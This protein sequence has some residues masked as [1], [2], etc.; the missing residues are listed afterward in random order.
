MYSVIGLK[1][2]YNMKVYLETVVVSNTNTTAV[3][4]IIL[5]FE[6]EIA[7]ADFKDTFDG[8]EKGPTFEV[9]RTLLPL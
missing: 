5:E 1:L 3:S 7:F 8:Y 2:G 6:D 4:Q 9:Y